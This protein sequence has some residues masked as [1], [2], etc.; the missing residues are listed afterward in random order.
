[1]TGLTLN[2]FSI[3]QI[4]GEDSILFL[5]FYKVPNTNDFVIRSSILF[6]SSLF[7]IFLKSPKCYLE[8]EILNSG[9]FGNDYFIYQDIRSSKLMLQILS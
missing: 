7:P 5:H 2:N 3:L 8:V 9:F 1:M 6:F 4:S